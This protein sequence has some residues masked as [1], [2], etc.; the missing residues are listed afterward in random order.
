[1]QQDVVLMERTGHIATI[2][3]NSPPVNAASIALLEAFHRALDDVEADSAIRCI[4]LL[5]MEQ[6][7]FCTGAGLRDESRLRDPAA[8]AAFRSLGRQTVQQIVFGRVRLR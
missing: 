7:A 4:I 1:M 2:L 3:F 6:K 8:S 5:V